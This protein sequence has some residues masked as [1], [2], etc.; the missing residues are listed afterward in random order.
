MPSIDYR[1]VPAP[2]PLDRWVRCFWFLR[3]DRGAPQ[4]VVP[5]GRLEIVVHRGE[6]FGRVRDDGTVERQEPVVVSGQITRPVVL[7]S[8]DGADIVGIR[9]RTAGARDL[10][11]L[12]LGGL[13]DWLVP[14]QDI[15][16]PLALRLRDAAHDPRRLARV[17]LDCV[18][19]RTHRD[20]ADAVR[21][22]ERGE[23][24]AAVGRALRICARTLERRVRDDVGL[25]PKPLQAVQRFRRYYALLLGGMGGSQAALT[26]GYYDQSHADRDF[27][28]LAG[29]SP[30][31]HF[32][33]ESGLAAAILSHSS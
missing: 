26:A 1:E 29:T 32:G 28:R 18:R 13:R 11:G 12:P 8:P 22:L 17:L 24:V 33:G 21:R 6:P 5:D 9:F 20:T 23:A 2:P 30:S 27:R 10:L 14:L 7:A 31:A 25:P 19:P 16:P 15:H 4:P 3:S